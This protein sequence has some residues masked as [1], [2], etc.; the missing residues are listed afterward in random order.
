MVNHVENTLFLLPVFFFFN[1]T[2]AASVWRMSSVFS[3]ET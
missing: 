2:I 1:V 3:S